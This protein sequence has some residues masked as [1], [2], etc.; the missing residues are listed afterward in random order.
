M[1]NHL[2]GVKH[3]TPPRRHIDFAEYTKL[4]FASGL[5]VTLHHPPMAYLPRSSLSPF[6]P[7]SHT[8]SPLSYETFFRGCLGEE[9]EAQRRENETYA[10]YDQKISIVFDQTDTGYASFSLSVPGLR[11]N[12]PF[13]EEDDVVEFRQLVHDMTGRL[14]GTDDYLATFRP[15]REN[16]PRLTS[17]PGWTGVI[18]HGRVTAVIKNSESLSVVVAGLPAINFGRD[19]RHSSRMQVELRFNVQFHVSASKHTAMHL[20]LST[21]QRTLADGTRGDYEEDTER[22]TAWLQSMLFP[23]E[24]DCAVQRKPHRGVFRQKFFDE[25]LNWEQKKAVEAVCK[26]DYGT[27]PYLVSGPPGTG[28]TKTI[29][30]MALQLIHADKR[31]RVLLCAPSETAADTLAIRLRDHFAT[32]VMLRL[33]RPTRTFAEVH[34]SIL[35]Y[36]HIQDDAFALPPLEKLLTYRAVVTSCRDASLL[37]QARV[38]NSDMYWLE[39][40]IIG[41]LRPLDKETTQ[42]L[43][44]T[45]LLID[46]AAQATEPE[47]LVPITVMAPPDAASIES[48]PIL[49]MVGD[50][51]QLAPR[52]CL[53][54]SPLKKSLFARL[55]ARPVY[56]RHPL[57]R[58]KRSSPPPVL[59][60]SMLPM[61]KP[62]FTNLIRNYRSHPSILAIPSALFYHDTLEPEAKG[63]DCLADWEG[64]RGRRWPVLFHQ[65]TGNDEIERD[66]GGWHNPSEVRLAL[67]YAAS[68]AS[69]GLVGQREICVMSPFKAQVIHLRAA[70]RQGGLWDVNVGPTEAFQGLEFDVV[71]LCTTRARDRFLSKDREVGWGVVGMKNAMNVALT[72]ARCGL[73]VIGRRGLLGTDPSWEVFLGFCERNGLVAGE[74]Y[75]GGWKAPEV[76]SAEECPR[77]EKVMLAQE[78]EVDKP[79]GSRA[80]GGVDVTDEMWVN[81]IHGQ[82]GSDEGE[83]EGWA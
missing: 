1:I 65:N 18:Y 53:P 71:I 2:P 59:K 83:G 14:H 76:V 23:T 51:H 66:G 4:A 6:G 8:F 46:E 62:A 80:L 25:Q 48:N 38:T 57:A 77:L 19:Y 44:W 75:E 73:V 36:C 5:Q 70:F 29:I 3:Q 9:L 45:A 58:G 31:S 64:W 34:S 37:L 33:N 20:A 63:T 17:I 27:L 54:N 7:P 11:E 49:V 79:V 15:L 22:Q 13:V 74:G 30:E 61:L 56:A 28:K 10:L 32:S 69:S 60:P 12:T 41:T 26:Q 82:P 24:A 42:R 35:H 72:R 47:A 78:A 40:S 50:E 16:Y 68:L 81:E 52:T 67:R 55:S 39:R 21:A 43:H